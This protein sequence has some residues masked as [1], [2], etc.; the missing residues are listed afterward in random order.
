MRCVVCCGVC[1][2]NLTNSASCVLKLSGVSSTCRIN[3][4]PLISPPPA[5]PEGT[6]TRPPVLP[7]V[8]VVPT[9]R[10]PEESMRM[11][12]AACE[13]PAPPVPILTLP[14]RPWTKYPCS[15]LVP[16]VLREVNSM[17]APLSVP[18]ASLP[19][20]AKRASV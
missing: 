1:V 15:Q 12:S 19:E 14:S 16:A 2:V 7:P 9:N 13:A 3:S 4:V 8:E 10:L 18:S 6:K 11:R 20:I 5:D 17:P